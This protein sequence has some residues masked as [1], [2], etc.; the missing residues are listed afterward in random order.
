MNWERTYLCYFLGKI[1][2]CPSGCPYQHGVVLLLFFCFY[3]LTSISIFCGSNTI[4][5]SN[6]NDRLTLSAGPVHW[7]K[8]FTWDLPSYPSST[9]LWGG[10]HSHTHFADE[11]TEDTVVEPL[12]QERTQARTSWDWDS[13]LCNW[14]QEPSC[15]PVVPGSL[16]PWSTYASYKAS[17][18]Q[19]PFS[20]H[21]Y[22]ALLTYL[23]DPLSSDSSTHEALSFCK[24]H[25]SHSIPSTGP[26]LKGVTSSMAMPILS[27]TWY[28]GK[29]PGDICFWISSAKELSLSIR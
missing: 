22:E 14:T 18:Y 9:T 17:I 10:Q 16:S 21:N 2:L 19:H 8:G 24:V 12:P 3:M 7:P 25:S 4:V 28:R 13:Q 23:L 11:R 15:Y 26:H 27:L 1:H 5:Q 20:W 6:G 29:C